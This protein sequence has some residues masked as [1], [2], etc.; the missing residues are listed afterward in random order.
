MAAFFIFFILSLSAS[1]LWHYENIESN[2][3]ANGK[4]HKSEDIFEHWR[5]YIIFE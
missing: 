4:K 5:E 1:P 3:V 2:Q